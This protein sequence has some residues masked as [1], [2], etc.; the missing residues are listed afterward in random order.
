MEKRRGKYD[1]LS[2]IRNR[3][4]PRI[5]EHWRTRVASDKSENP[6]HNDEGLILKMMGHPTL[7]QGLIAEM[8]AGYNFMYKNPYTDR[9]YTYDDIG[10]ILERLFAEKSYGE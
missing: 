8:D 2:A 1:Y 5:G 7:L 6:L 10:L 9:T 3:M 4:V